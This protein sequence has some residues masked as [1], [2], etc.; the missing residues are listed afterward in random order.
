MPDYTIVVDAREKKPLPLPS[1]LL[2]LS[3]SALP[4]TRQSTWVGVKQTRREIPA[5]DY[6]LDGEPGVC[7]SLGGSVIVERKA[8]LDEIATNCL[9]S[10]RRQRFVRCL[11]AM[12]RSH[13]RPFLIFEGG[14]SRMYKASSSNPHPELAIDALQRLCFAHGVHLLAISGDSLACRRH[15]GDYVA[16]MLINGALTWQPSPQ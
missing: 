16:R 7:Y 2:M 6:C 11:E 1:R 10:Y 13:A 9:D 12:R 3:P 5:A 8:A 14:L 15:L 4:E